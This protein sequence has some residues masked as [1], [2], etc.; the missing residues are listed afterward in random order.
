MSLRRRC[1]WKYPHPHRAG[2]VVDCQLWHYSKVGNIGTYNN[3]NASSLRAVP[4]NNG[5]SQN[6]PSYSPSPPTPPLA[7]P[8]LYSED[9]QHFTHCRHDRQ[10][11]DQI[12]DEDVSARVG[13]VADKKLLKVVAIT[14]YQGRRNIY[15]QFVK[16]NLTISLL[17]LRLIYHFE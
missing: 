11:D 3:A 14:G 16:Y 9:R 5:S 8:G 13:E 10:T 1:R 4:F 15:G 7:H 12:D 6:L 17:Y 2:W